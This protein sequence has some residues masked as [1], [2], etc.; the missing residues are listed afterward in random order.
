MLKAPSKDIQ[1]T[2]RKRREKQRGLALLICAFGVWGAAGAVGS[3]RG[4]RGSRGSRGKGGLPP[5]NWITGPLAGAPRALIG[6]PA[7]T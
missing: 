2:G 5:P 6:I 4:L 3:R 7:L 1:P